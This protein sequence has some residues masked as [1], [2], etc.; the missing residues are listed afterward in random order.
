M[1]TCSA[2]TR[3]RHSVQVALWPSLLGNSHSLACDNRVLI[4]YRET[5]D[6]RSAC[7]LATGFLVQYMTTTIACLVLAFVRSP[8]LTVVILSTI[9]ILIF[10]QGLSQ[11]F[12]TPLQGRERQQTAVAA[13]I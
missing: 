7:A 11:R 3:T 10:V 4:R 9:P 2:L 13:T 5:D 6:V 12:A 8:L 1:V